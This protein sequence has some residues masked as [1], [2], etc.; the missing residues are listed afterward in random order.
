M[1]TKKVALGAVL[2]VVSSVVL[3][4]TGALRDT[5]LLIPAAIASLGMAAGALLVGT[6][7]D[8]RPV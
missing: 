5:S 6:A 4:A 8:G 2:L 1:D 7:G 3:L